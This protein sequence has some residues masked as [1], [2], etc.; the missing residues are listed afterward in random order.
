MT[1]IDMKNT[2]I[3]ELQ[4][5]LDEANNNWKRAL[6]DYQNLEKRV[7]GERYDLACFANRELIIKLLPVIDTFNKLKEHLRDQGL[8][9]AIKQF[10]DILKTEGLEKIE[11][12]GKD[13]D[14]LEMECVE[15]VEGEE[16]KVLK[17]TREGYTMKGKIIKPSQV[18]VGQKKVEEKVVTN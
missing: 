6:A 14:P 4:K 8:D 7:A 5:Q 18:V 3:E 2:K 1:K 11:V 12:L 15:A 13:F 10:S 9:L 16:N 17:E